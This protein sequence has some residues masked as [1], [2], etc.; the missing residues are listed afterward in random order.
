MYSVAAKVHR[1]QSVAVTAK[2]RNT[3]IGQTSTVCEITMIWGNQRMRNGRKI[4]LFVLLQTF[5]FAKFRLCSR[6]L[7][8]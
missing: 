5:S 4:L 6:R 7:L 2:K 3:Q 8:H 1:P